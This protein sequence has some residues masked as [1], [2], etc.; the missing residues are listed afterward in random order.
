MKALIGVVAM[1][2]A[3]D[4]ANFAAGARLGPAQHGPSL[5]NALGSDDFND[6][7]PEALA[8][9]PASQRQAFEARLA[10]TKSFHSLLQ[11]PPATA[12]FPQEIVFSAKVR[13]ERAAFVLTTSG[14][15]ARDAAELA[16]NVRLSYEW[17]GYPD[18]PMAEAQSAQRY[19][20]G[21]PNTS[22]KDYIQLF[23]MHRY[24]CAFEAAERTI[25]EALGRPEPNGLAWAEQTRRVQRDAAVAYR[26]AW[27]RARN[28][29]DEVARTIASD[30]DA[31]S[32]VYV[33]TAAHPRTFKDK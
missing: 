6:K 22:V 26:A 24:R 10:R 5:F 18:G 21:H 16:G 4:A 33:A 27:E 3:L 15:A 11:A 9:L 28:S 23:L 12:E 20:A 8:A 1:V 29:R 30:I 25:P 31:A 17:E 14:N 32:Y 19:L 7:L 2:L 13:V